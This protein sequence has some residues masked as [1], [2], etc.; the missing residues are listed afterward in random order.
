M[1]AGSGVEIRI[2]RA[3]D[4]CRR[5]AGRKARY[6]DA[7]G[8]NAEIAHDLLCDPCDQRGLALVAEVDP[9]R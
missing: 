9:R 7:F 1:N 3:H 2:N 4:S 5:T 6:E 8:L